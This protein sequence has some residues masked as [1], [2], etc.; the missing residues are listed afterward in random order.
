MTDSTA[1]LAV[2]EQ[3]ARPA[4]VDALVGGATN[5][6]RS[7]LYYPEA[8]VTKPTQAGRIVPLV[9]MLALAARA[10]A[11]VIPPAGPPPGQ[12]TGMIVGQ[13]VDAST[14]APISEA[15]VRLT[16]PKYFEDPTTP[17]GRVMADGEGRFFFT[18]LHPGEYFLQ[19]T[20]DG[21][22]PGTYGQRRAEGQSQLLSLAEGERLAD[23]TLR[24]WKHGVIAGTVVDEAGEP[25]VGVAVRALV[26]NVVAGR[27]RYGN[28]QF[29]CRADC[30]DRRSRHVPAVAVDA[31]DLR[32]PR[33]VHAD[34]RAGGVS[35]KAGRHGAERALFRG[36]PRGGAARATAHATGGRRRPHDVESR[37]GSSASVAGRPHDVCTRRRT[38]RRRPRLAR[39]RRSRSPPARRG[40][41]SRSRCG[42]CRQYACPAV[43]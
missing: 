9:V 34:H 24:V 40:R 17:K 28:L 1:V 11:Q 29:H 37:A 26:K 5:R 18:D 41:T 16:M 22:A 14:G 31:R 32:G 33:A 8:A 43:S 30:D 4:R 23:V 7:A 6:R 19:A 12:R 3:H 15:I 10:S 25:V 38:F 13:V 20:K 27:P 36:R 39:R 42:R 35:G 21:Y 2:G